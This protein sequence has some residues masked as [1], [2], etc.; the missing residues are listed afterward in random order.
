MR[1]KRFLSL[2]AILLVLS[3][4]ANVSGLLGQEDDFVGIVLSNNGSVIVIEAW[5]DVAKKAYNINI[6]ISTSG[7]II[8]KIFDD[9]DRTVELSVSDI[10][11]YYVIHGTGE[12]QA[13]G[14]ILAAEIIIDGPAEPP[15]GPK[16]GETFQ[17][18]GEVVEVGTNYIKVRWEDP[19]SGESGVDEIKLDAGTSITYE[20]Q[21]QTAIAVGNFVDGDVEMQEDGSILAISIT[22]YSPGPQPGDRIQFL[23]KILSIGS[24]SIEVEVYDPDGEIHVEKGPRDASITVT[25]KDGNPASIDILAVGDF[26][27]GEVEILEADEVK[28]LWIR[29]L[30]EKPPLPG[31]E[32]S[33]AG[34]VVSV[35][36]DYIEVEV[37]G[38]DGSPDTLRLSV[39]N[40]TELKDETGSVIR[41]SDFAAGEE[42]H[43]TFDASCSPT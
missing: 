39:D 11:D 4:T 17:F 1:F 13:N 6:L 43:G 19:Q 30:S 18:G 26:I 35:G 23:A 8:T 31:E 9:K 41:L 21:S 7:N 42:V 2:S 20:N 25:D 22:V 5:D 36:G 33:F 28:V 32:A 16:P 34:R 3:L 10:P 24:D 12:K 29:V 37:P 27:E 14:D 15:P 40:A 38:P